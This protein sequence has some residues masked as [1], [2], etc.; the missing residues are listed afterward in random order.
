M[1]RAA[2]DGSQFIVATHSPI[3]LALPSARIYELGEAGAQE[4]AWEDTDVV[5]LTRSFL[6]LPDR[7]LRELL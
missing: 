1:H 2:E 5:R 6:E 3:L 4:T 7:F